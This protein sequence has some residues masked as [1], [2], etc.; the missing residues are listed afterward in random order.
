MEQL[1]KITKDTHGNEVVSARE[2]HSFLEVE[3]RF[4]DWIPRMF[5]YGFIEGV[6]YSKMSTDNQGF[7]YDYI[8]TID[9]AKE[10]SMLQRS[11]KGKQARQYFIE[12]ERM[13]RQLTMPSGDQLIQQAMMILNDRI[14]QQQKQLAITIP[15]ADFADRVIGS[16]SV[17]T[18]TVIA[19]EL[20][21]TAEQLNQFLH[22]EGIQYKCDGVWVLYKKYQDKGLSE[23]KTEVKNGFTIRIMKW[24]E[25][26][27]AFIMNKVK[28]LQRFTEAKSIPTFKE[29]SRLVN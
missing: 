13:A 28:P 11:E 7:N 22:K 8:L 20:G 6:D 17:F 5:K 3:T 12:C 19:K 10:I 25:Y 15:K 27:R 26:G 9:T 2:L 1:I 24:T 29:V 14:E 4:N 16:K 18:T 23:L 21:M